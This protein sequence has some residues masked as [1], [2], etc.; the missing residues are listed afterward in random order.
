[1]ELTKTI[2]IT[3]EDNMNLMK[4]Y[5]D[6]YFD[7][8][9]VDPPYFSGPN[10]RKFYGRKESKTG[11]KRVEYDVIPDWEVPGEEYFKE[12]YRVC[13]DVIIWGCNY[14]EQFIDFPGRIVWDKVNGDSTF[15]DAEIAACSLHDSVRLFRYMWNGAMQG[16]SMYDGAKMQG[17]KTLN[18]KRIHPTQKPVALYNWLLTKYA[19]PGYKILD[20]HIG[21]GSIAISCHDF[22]AELIACDK[23][24]VIY[25][26]AV[27]RIQEHIDFKKTQI[28]F[29]EWE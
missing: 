18:E 12:L 6:G 8:G 16:E 13:K 27:K 2:T 28:N 20:T 9:I 5:P 1:M 22:G 25:K 23:D 17:N 26:K 10:K 15:S 11:I 7:L 21:S 14:Y 29:P 4:R 3:E 24:P 19:K